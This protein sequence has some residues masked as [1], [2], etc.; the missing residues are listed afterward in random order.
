M[1]WSGFVGRH[2]DAALNRALAG[3]ANLT[4]IFAVLFAI[5]LAAWV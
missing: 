3:T 5:G 2:A 4:L 1:H